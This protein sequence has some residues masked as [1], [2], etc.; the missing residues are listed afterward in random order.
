MKVKEAVNKHKLDKRRR[1]FSWYGNIVYNS[2]ISLQCSNCYGGGC[3]EC[4]GK[5]K[6]RHPVPIPAF[7]EK[8]NTISVSDKDLTYYK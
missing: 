2:W 6:S 7:D 5:G 3:F 4:G 8:G 1:W